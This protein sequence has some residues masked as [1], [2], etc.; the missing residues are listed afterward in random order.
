MYAGLQGAEGRSEGFLQYL[1]VLFI[2]WRSRSR[3]KFRLLKDPG[4]KTK[5]LETQRPEY[6]EPGNVT[7]SD[8]RQDELGEVKVEVNYGVQG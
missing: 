2:M 4:N 3:S 1:R 6:A 5:H 8:K 7:M